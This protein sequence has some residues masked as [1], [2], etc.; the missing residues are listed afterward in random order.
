MSRIGKLSI[1]IPEGVTVSLDGNTIKVIGTKGALVRKFSKDITI[2]KSENEIKL[3]EK[4]KT[5]R[6]SALYGTTRAILANM[7][8]GV[9][10]G[11]LK[12]LELVGTGYRADVSG[13]VLTLTVGFSH[14]IK[15]KAPPG[16]SFKVE[17]TDVSVEGP[18]K[19][20]V[21]QV[22]ASLRAIRKPEP[23]KGK[24]IKYK[25]EV[26][27]RKAGKAAKTVGAAA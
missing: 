20:V 24:G 6:S 15:V 5:S 4:R 7:I 23:Y 26:I 27:R 21:G 19:E 13:D 25:D 18:D 9:T 8:I 2:E 22:A 3:L 10:T 1:Q 17:K 16:I 12:T 11:W 14:P